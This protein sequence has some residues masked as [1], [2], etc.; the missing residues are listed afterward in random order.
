MNSAIARQL[1]Q[2]AYSD[3]SAHR[4]DARAKALAAL[5]FCGTVIS[6]PKYTLASLIPF[7]IFPVALAI[8]GGVPL[9]PLAA[10]IIRTAP[11]AV[12]VGI[13]NPFFDRA[14]HLVLFGVT[15]SGGWI[16]FFSIIARFILTVAAV[17]I[18]VATTPFP[19]LGIGLARLGLPRIFVDQLL[20]LYRYL[21]LLMEEGQ[22]MARAAALRL[23][24]RRMPNFRVAVE[25]MAMLFLR[26]WNR[27]ERIYHCMEVRGFNGPLIKTV[28]DRF[29]LTDGVFLATTIIFCLVLRFYPPHE[30]IG[31][32]WLRMIQ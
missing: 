28:P 31:E 11:F 13:F 22:T 24:S 23:N 25:M 7:A 2:H 10:A 26:S 29:S 15:I 27:A 17:L 19:K 20:V 32:I 9:R 1:D 12:A 3:T 5:F 8:I 6:F 16:S 4:L 21:F 18:L 30:I 14:P